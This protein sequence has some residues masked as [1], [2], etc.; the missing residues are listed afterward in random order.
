VNLSDRAT[1]GYDTG[2]LAAGLVALMKALG[3]SRFAMTGHDVGMWTSYALA[4]DHPERLARLAVAESD[5]PGISPATP[6]WGPARANDMLW[7]FSFNRL[8]DLNEALVRDREDVF[9]GWH[10]VNPSDA[11]MLILN[12]APHRPLDHVRVW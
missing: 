7:H 8:T 12:D 3:H 10:M 9:F 6:P 11:A 5:I 1:G 4:A 2:N